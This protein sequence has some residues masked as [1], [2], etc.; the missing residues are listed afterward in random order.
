MMASITEYQWSEN[1]EWKVWEF[2][3]NNSL[4]FQLFF[5]NELQ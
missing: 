1:N 5:I 4:L 2:V 3:T